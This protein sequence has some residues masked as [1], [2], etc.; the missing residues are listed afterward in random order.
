MLARN[1]PTP[2]TAFAAPLRAS[3]SQPISEP[4]YPR[5]GGFRVKPFRQY[6][7]QVKGGFA[8]IGVDV[9]TPLAQRFNLR[10]GASFFQYSGSYSIDGILIDG[11]AKFRSATA[12]VDIFPFNNAFRISLGATVYNGNN[13]NAVAMVPGGQSF[14]LGDGSYTSSPYDPVHGT[15][16]LTFGNRTAPSVT[17]GFGNMIPRNGRHWSVPFEIGFQYI[18]DPK[19]DIVLGG[20]ACYEGVY[21]APISSDPQ[22]QADLQQEIDEVNS[23]IHPLRFYPIIST[24]VAYRF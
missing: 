20:T 9:A 5:A 2:A 16:S 13:L 8:G 23:D 7:V 21:C 3:V 11:E 10:A 4:S 12:Q 6:A 17:V 15:A 24:G 18:A 1:T 22:T 14:D 19:I